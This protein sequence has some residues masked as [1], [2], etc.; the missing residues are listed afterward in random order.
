[1]TFAELHAALTAAIVTQA[2]TGN[3]KAKAFAAT[4]SAHYAVEACASGIDDEIGVHYGGS[5]AYGRRGGTHWRQQRGSNRPPGNQQFSS[6]QSQI[7]HR[8][9]P[10]AE[11]RVCWRCKRPGHLSYQCGT[12]QSMRDAVR[13][14]VRESGNNPT[15]AASTLFALADDL[16]AARQ[17]L[18]LSHRFIINSTYHTKLCQVEGA[19]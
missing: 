4:S 16:D 14:R 15:S 1:M 17:E 9:A 7:N 5:Y 6:Q 3:A 18:N 19:I 2:D 10:R 12:V 8:H 11:N 13:A